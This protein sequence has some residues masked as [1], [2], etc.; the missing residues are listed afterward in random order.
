M[1]KR[2]TG[3]LES[4]TEYHVPRSMSD[5]NLSCGDLAM[6]ASSRRVPTSLVPINLNSSLMSIRPREKTVTFEDDK[7][8]VQKCPH[9]VPTTPMRKT[10]DTNVLGDVFM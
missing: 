5:F 10:T 6:P 4:H 2:S 3:V 7:N 9:G 1:E 8:I